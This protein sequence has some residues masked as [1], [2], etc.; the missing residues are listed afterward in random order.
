MDKAKSSEIGYSHMERVLVHILETKFHI[1]MAID[2]QL[3]V[4]LNPT[5]KDFVINMPTAKK[6][7]SKRKKEESMIEAAESVGENQPI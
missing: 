6:K 1:E 2:L 5:M 4:R 3:E 7:R